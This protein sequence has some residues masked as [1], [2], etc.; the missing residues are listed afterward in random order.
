M[1]RRSFILIALF[2]AA[3]ARQGVPSVGVQSPSD[4]ADLLIRL[5]ESWNA[6]DAKAAADCFT[7]DA[8][9][10]EPPQKQVYSGRAALFEFFG[11]D[12]GRAGAMNMRWHRIVFD[13]ENQQGMGEFTFRYGSQVHGVAVIDLR[14][15]LISQWREYWYSSEQSFD[16]FV[17][18]SRR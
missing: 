5:A 2:F 16:E 3:C 17:A 4:L 15:G 1:R 10:V 13:A 18:P 12:A 11:G 6:G 8:I 14:G 7:D 9:Y